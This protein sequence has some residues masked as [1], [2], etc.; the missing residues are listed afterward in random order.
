MEPI[1]QKVQVLELKLQE[2]EARLDKAKQFAVE[3]RKKARMWEASW[4]RISLSGILAYAAAWTYLWLVGERDPWI[5]AATPV[6]VVTT[7]TVVMPLFR[8]KWWNWDAEGKVTKH[9][10]PIQRSI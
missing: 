10:D 1:E 9:D 4:I 6:V 2:V 3:R 8:R 7:F 5:R